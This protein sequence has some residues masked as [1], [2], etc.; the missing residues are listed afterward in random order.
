MILENNSNKSISLEY[1]LL[2]VLLLFMLN[3]ATETPKTVI[4]ES[5]NTNDVVKEVVYLEL[6][7]EDENKEENITSEK[8]IELPK[9]S[10]KNKK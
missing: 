2:V 10:N 5:N 9:Y 3:F 6:E 7:L 4:V 8:T 1:Y